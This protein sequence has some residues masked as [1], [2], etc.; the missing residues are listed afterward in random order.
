M[1]P[2]RFEP[3]MTSKRAGSSTNLAHQR[4]DVLL[5]ASVDVGVARPPARAT[6]SSQNGI[7]WM[8]PFDLVAEVDAA[9]RAARRARTRSA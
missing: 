9:A 6:I 2:N 8:I 1:S 7:V 3:T 4:V 5:V